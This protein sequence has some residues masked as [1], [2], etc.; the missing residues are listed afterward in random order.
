[1][2][3]ALAISGSSASLP[4]GLLGTHNVRHQ[5][6]SVCAFGH[7]ARCY[8]FLEIYPRIS[9]RK[10][11]AVIDRDRYDRSCPQPGFSEPD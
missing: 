5:L 8:I 1:M 3:P 4:I 9:T 11:Q 7:S 6:A 10:L 2:K